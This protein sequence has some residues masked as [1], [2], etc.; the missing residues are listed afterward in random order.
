MEGLNINNPKLTLVTDLIAKIIEPENIGDLHTRLML[1]YSGKYSIR[2]PL[3]EGLILSFY[4][5]LW[6]KNDPLYNKLELVVYPGDHLENCFIDVRSE[7]MCLD[8]KLAPLLSVRNTFISCFVN[9]Q[10]ALAVKRNYLA[11]FFA[12]KINHHQDDVDKSIMEQR[13]THH[14][15]VALEITGSYIAKDLPFFSI[16]IA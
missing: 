9:H 6:N 15:L 16:N 7:D 8:A 10:D 2:K 5:I 3:V 1:K 11:E 14:G 4:K 13:L 12:N